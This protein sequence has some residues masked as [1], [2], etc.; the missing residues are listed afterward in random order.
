MAEECRKWGFIKIVTAAP[1]DVP[2]D[3]KKPA[4]KQL[5]EEEPLE[6]TP[7]E[8]EFD[9]SGFGSGD[10]VID[11]EADDL[12]LQS[13]PELEAP[14]DTILNTTAVP[15]KKPLEPEEKLKKIID[16]WPSKQE[17]QPKGWMH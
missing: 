3:D 7:S 4:E 8:L 10:L 9:L 17:D 14:P 16:D 12:Q 13:A 6:L 11:L 2:V 5:D 15:M 1:E